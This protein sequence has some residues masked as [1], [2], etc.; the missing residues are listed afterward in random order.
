MGMK[1][2]NERTLTHVVGPLAGLLLVILLFA[3]TPGFLS[4][5]NLKFILSQTVIISIC[6][7]GATFIII[8]GGIDLSVG[9][10]VALTSVIGATLLEAGAPAGAALSGAIGGGLA[11]G[12]VNGAVVAWLRINPFIVTLGMMGI[13]RG[14]AKWIAHNQTVNYETGSALNRI[15]NNPPDYPLWLPTPGVWVAL[16]LALAMGV[17]LARTV[18]GRHV[19][20]IGSNEATARLCGIAIERRKLLIYGMAGALYGVAGLMQMA[21][22]QQGS[23]TVAIG[24]ELDVIAAVVIGGASLS[25]GVGSIFGAVVGALIMSCLRNGTQLMGWETYIQEIII[26]AII[27]VAVGLDRLR[28]AN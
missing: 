11:C 16:L 28:R 21:R 7:L 15:M 23:P 2:L 4:A 5:V 19:Y 14:M 24:L 17:L 12:L 3:W 8:G 9:S 22:L 26:G 6:A 10:V 1:F 27:I 13:V 20:A 18:F 25:G